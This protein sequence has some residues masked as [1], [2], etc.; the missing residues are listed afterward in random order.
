MRD[1]RLRDY[2]LIW[3]DRQLKAALGEACKIT[4]NWTVKAVDPEPFPPNRHERRKA[5]S[6]A[7]RAKERV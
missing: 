5:K 2:R 3:D 7:R 1:G 6:L 4:T